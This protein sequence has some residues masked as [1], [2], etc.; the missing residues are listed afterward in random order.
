LVVRPHGKIHLKQIPNVKLSDAIMPIEYSQQMGN[1]FEFMRLNTQNIQT[2]TGV[3]PYQTGG[4]TKE[5]KVERATVANRLSFAGSAR[6]RE[7]SRHME[8]SMVKSVT[9]HFVAIIQFY[10][11][12]AD[13]FSKDG[14]LPIETQ[15]AGKSYFIKYLPKSN[16]EITEED[17]A[18]AIQEGYVGIIAQDQIQGRYKVVTQ[19]GSSLPTDPDEKARLKL[20]FL[21]LAQTVTETKMEQG[22]DPKTGMT[23]QMPVPKPI[24]NIKRIA[25]EVAK[26]MFEITDPDDYMAE[27]VPAPESTP[28]N[29]AMPEISPSI[30]PAEQPANI[31]Q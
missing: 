24:F 14:G 1:Y 18:Q 25:E 2:V 10:Y 29:P 26:E 15:K 12:N 21:K 13:P 20:E 16:G 8:D 17:R 7:I 22:T 3:S 31:I 27:E 23:T 5:S 9:E 4:V 19:G 28:A 6:I 30:N 11:Q